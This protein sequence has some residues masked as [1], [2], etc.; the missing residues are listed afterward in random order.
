MNVI[1]T[2]P[3]RNV[4]PLTLINAKGLLKSISPEAKAKA[5]SIDYLGLDLMV[6]VREFRKTHNP[7]IAAEVDLR[8]AYLV[9]TYG[10]SAL[11]LDLVE[12]E[13]LLLISDCAPEEV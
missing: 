7:K 8:A 12:L 10:E 6:Y 4:C 3:V 13:E 1:N 9:E 11:P 5:R 2:A